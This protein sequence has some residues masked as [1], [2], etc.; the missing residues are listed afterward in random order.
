[1]TPNLSPSPQVRR[2][3]HDAASETGGDACPQRGGGHLL[4]ARQHQ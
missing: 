3:E 1:M 2:P 4:H